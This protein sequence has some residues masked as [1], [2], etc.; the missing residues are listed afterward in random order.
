MAT[1]R[2]L[3]RSVTAGQTFNG[4]TGETSGGY[5]PVP[6]Q[7][8]R[9]YKSG[10]TVGRFGFGV[11]G[12]KGIAMAL[13]KVRVYGPV[14]AGDRVEIRS[15]ISG[16]TP[17]GDRD[18][19]P[20]GTTADGPVEPLQLP[21]NQLLE[22]FDLV[23]N[24][25]DAGWH[26]LGPTD[27]IC[28][29]HAA[30]PDGDTV[31]LLIVEGDESEL[32]AIEGCNDCACDC[33]VDTLTVLGTSEG[34]GPI[35]PWE[36]DISIILEPLIAS[37]AF[38]LPAAGGMTPGATA[39]IRRG[40]GRPWC[41]VK[42]APGET[43]NGVLEPS[44]II[45]Q[46]DDKGVLFRLTS[47]GWIANDLI[48]QLTPQSLFA[49]TVPVFYGNAVFNLHPPSNSV[50]LPSTT[51][52]AQGQMLWLT[53]RSGRSGI[54]V[55]VATAGENID[56]VA[57]AVIHL[58]NI[59]DTVLLL[60]DGA[61]GWRSVWNR[62]DRA[63]QLETTA[64]AALAI[65]AYRGTRSYELTAGNANIAVTLPASSAAFVGMRLYAYR[66]ADGT[67]TFDSGVGGRIVG[68]GLSAQTLVVDGSY[69][70]GFLEFEGVNLAG[71]GIWSYHCCELTQARPTPIT[72]TNAT[73]VALAAL[74]RDV[75]IQEVVC[76]AVGGNVDL[77]VLSGQANLKRLL[78][79]FNSGT[80]RL[81]INPTG[82]ATINGAPGGIELPSFGGTEFQPDDLGNWHAI[83][84]ATL[85]P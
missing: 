39:F 12:R 73:T 71:S 22:V 67:I 28:V 65:A 59:G 21:Q 66:T 76:N 35:A 13:V 79:L 80:E 2:V 1:E 48:P 70:W 24:F 43:I 57:D 53:N 16:E 51:Q 64:S 3:V 27:A 18:N 72:L 15:G 19:Q 78:K 8:A 61:D 14:V 17:L 84:G 74:T 46:D 38:T 9:S 55:S 45:F 20:V 49:A 5:F 63:I 68:A 34:T 26:R 44:G 29:Y 77:P 58:P 11:Q 75:T 36:C 30:A 60:R 83:V 52:I 23:N 54:T 4:I 31:E 33:R 69:N 32:G 47:S 85:A 7:N 25:T 37:T 62:W 41:R 50:S 82:G 56:G 10:T 6:T 40:T 81:T 42:A